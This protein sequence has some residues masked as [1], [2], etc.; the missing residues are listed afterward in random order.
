MIHPAASLVHFRTQQDFQSFVHRIHELP[1][2]RGRHRVDASFEFRFLAGKLLGSVSRLNG[3]PLLEF[4][5]GF[6]PV[7]TVENF[8]PCRLLLGGKRNFASGR[9]LGRQAGSSG[10]LQAKC[11]TEPNDG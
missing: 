2:L 1:Q 6:F 11:Q 7:L 5:A 9:F 3:H 4:F 10:R 8:P